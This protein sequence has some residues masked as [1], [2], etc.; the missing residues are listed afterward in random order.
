MDESLNE[1]VPRVASRQG[2]LSELPLAALVVLADGEVV[3]ANDAAIALTGFDLSEL[4]GQ[5]VHKL[6]GSE[7]DARLTHDFN[8]NV[9]DG[10]GFAGELLC[11]QKSGAPFWNDIVV[12]PERATG[13]TRSLL[14]LMRDVTARRTA[15][16]AL[17][18]DVS[19]DRMILD[20]IQAAVIVHS[21]STEILYANALAAEML[22]VTYD[23]VLGAGHTDPRWKFFGG[24]GQ[25]LPLAE[26]PVGHLQLLSSHRRVGCNSRSGGVLC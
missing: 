8:R 7:T 21:A 6:F 11:Y 26:F 4:V 19:H 14:V 10:N 24:D 20:R 12:V 1:G 13:D 3:E 18:V 25:P 23:S 15:A 5:P 9:A 16:R 17:G 2:S 22:G